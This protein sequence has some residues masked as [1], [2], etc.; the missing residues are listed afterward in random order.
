MPRYAPLPI[1]SID[2]RNETN[3]VQQAAQVVYEAS[4][5]TLNDFSAGNPLAAL[6]EGQAF[7]QGELLFWANQ[8]PDKILLE[9][10]G[11][12][13]G[14]MR[15]LGTPAVAEVIVT[16]NPQ[17][18]ATN[19][20]SGTSFTT[21]SQ[22]SGGQSYEFTSYADVT[23]PAGGT[24]GKVPVY[25]K[26]VGTAYNVPANS[27]TGSSSLS[28]VAISV[29]NPKPAVG[30]SDVETYQQVRER[31]FTLI[32]R[33]NLVSE[34]DWQ[35]FFTDL[36]GIGTITSVQPNR[37]SKFA[38]N[39]NTD[40]SKPNGQVS[41]FVLGPSGVELTETELKNGQNA[42]NFLV[43][44]ENQGH[45][46]PI[47]LSQV[48]YNLTV[49]V[50][51]NGFYGTDYRQ[52]SL[53]FR[54]ILYQVL[55]P[56]TTF[57][58]TIN[59]TVS[60]VDAAF[61]TYFLPD[62]RFIDPHIVSSLAYNTPNSLG[63]NSA[64]Y[65]RIFDFSPTQNLISKN[66]LVTVNTPNPSFYPALNSFT[67]YSIDKFDQTIYGNL[68]LKQI[69]NLSSGS[70]KLGDIVYYNGAESL[71]QKGLHVVLENINI[72]SPTELLLYISSGK[73]SDVKTYS[74]WS[75]GNTYQ[76]S[77][78]GTIDPEI[79]EYDYEDGDFIP[80]YPSD[81]PLN[82]RP[83]SFAWLVGNNFTL[84]NP[85]NDITGAQADFKLGS[86]I[87]PEEL[88]PNNTYSA[89][90]WVSTPQI[91]S[92]PNQEI[93]SNYYYVDITKGV[94]VKYAY[95]TSTFTYNPDSEKVSDYFDKI[96]EQGLIEE[97]MIFDG[98][99]GLP[100]YKYKPRFKGGQYL[101]YR[102]TSNS[103]PSYYIASKFFTPD[104]TNIQKLL[105]RGVVLSLTPNPELKK[106]FEEELPKGF[107][108]QLGKLSISY[109][110]DGYVDGNYVN[111][112]LIGGDGIG[113]TADITIYGGKAV[114]VFPNNR[115]QAYRV[116]DIFSVDNSFLG[117]SGSDLHL[118]ALSIYPP[119]KTPLTKPVRMFTFF[120]GDI[121]FFRNGSDIRAYVA[122]SSVTPVFDFEVYYSNKIFVE[123]SEYNFGSSYEASIPYN[124]PIY[125]NYAED[126]ITAD[127]GG[128]F[129]RVMEAFTPQVSVVSF[130]GLTQ[131]NSCR[132]EEFTGNLLK[133][134]SE[135]VC[136]EP[137]L[138]Q[139]SK[140]TSS[141][142]L[143][144]CQITI[145]PKSSTTTKDS[146]QNL[147]YIWENTN[148]SLEQSILSW[149][150]GSPSNL[151]P[152]DYS[153]GTLSL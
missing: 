110:G 69:K 95:V 142:K 55:V 90:S 25:S 87:I 143:G 121:T 24:E 64:T 8:L 14:A 133:I 147:V 11:P 135:Y 54:N 20:P 101:E 104:S 32:R 86:S 60:D 74:A 3:L 38:Y 151:T 68:Q 53:N 106:Q 5:R 134:V 141:I 85:T 4:N 21:N 51:S 2:P 58:V 22:V 127:N 43:P 89:G 93:D 77:S 6:L 114:S 73:V 79:I 94:V 62:S 28:Q 108:G 123:S 35:D 72:S 111:V 46:F 132:Y 10:I 65:S 144:N 152:P 149:Y 67:P 137:I 140:E 27:I 63:I 45:L 41:F 49:E 100:I 130:N 88:I 113:A 116:G 153:Q 71:S 70:F 52:S 91:G 40:Y 112:P 61:Y 18:L 129:Y 102:E 42:I 30:G 17:N 83:G 98:N 80:S 50:D 99:G 117:G 36:Y 146:N 119:E 39:Y 12:F 66:D 139:F 76:Y 75:V 118:V 109:S 131:A 138:P 37:S 124:N 23:I 19:I 16:I 1:V 122:T 92:G 29:T 126:V 136:E 56:G 31:F 82:N 33:R 78:N 120:Q 105:D 125:A 7:A 107:S 44:I 84:N 115:G 57:P 145:I 103:S 13:L 81:V 96:V 128:S 34:T 47:T 48:Q 9:W 148:S 59:P 150:S 97:V 26:F 15:R